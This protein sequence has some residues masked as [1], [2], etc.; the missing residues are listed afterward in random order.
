MDGRK[1]LDC[2]NRSDL[3]E[4]L[5]IDVK[6]LTYLAYGN[7]KRYEEFHI[8]RKSG[9]TRLISAP[10]GPLITVQRRLAKY[11]VEIYNPPASVNGF[12][13]DRSIVTNAV[14]HLRKRTILNVDLMNF[15]P[16]ISD[17]RIIGL[18]RA[19]P[20]CFNDVVASTITGLVCYRGSLPQGAPTSP[21][22]SNMI[23]LRLDNQ[24]TKF[25]RELHLTYTRYADDITLSTAKKD[26]PEAVAKVN[27][28]GSIK[29]SQPFRAIIAR[30][31]FSLNTKK[32][33]ISSDDQSKFVTGVKVNTRLNVSSKYISE[34]RAMIYAAQKHGLKGAQNF[35]DHKF[36]GNGRK[37]EN[38]LYGKLEY[39][40]NVRGY[41]DLTYRSLYNKYLSIEGIKGVEF[42]MSPDQEL[43]DKILV[44]HGAGNGTGFILDNEW[45]ITCDHVVDT[46]SSA[47]YFTYNN[48][49]GPTRHPLTINHNWRSSEKAFDLIA[50]EP[51]LS[52]L[53]SGLFSF[54]SAPLDSV[55]ESETYRVVG[56]PAY[57]A[58]SRPHINPVT[59]TGIRT[60]DG[61]QTAFVNNSLISGY[62][63]SPVLNK[64]N[65]VVGIVQTGSPNRRAGED[66]YRHTFL[67]IS[68]IKRCLDGFRKIT[69]ED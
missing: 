11:L 32:T 38:V 9:G 25:C 28:D 15:F 27:E 19:K 46:A 66:D 50:L 6:T 29:I 49:A 13:N 58:G 44:V 57:I 24:L 35:F 12:T 17:T 55:H 31:N 33:R 65:Q 3:A 63:G 37:Y 41:Y 47:E 68:E 67:P 21:V 16:S 18:L 39:L 61:F 2:Q 26:L 5:R 51:S 42:P 45:L 34:L 10:Q 64:L 23:C 36:Q 53:H 14:A 7:G 43:L 59:V 40:K 60:I 30:N 52:D 20:F 48:Y 62:S 69:S 54:E 4:L 22:L 8:P 56:F 1:L